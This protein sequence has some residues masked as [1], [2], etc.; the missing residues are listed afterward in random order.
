MKK[1]HNDLTPP[2]KLVPDLSERIDWAIR[3]AMSADPEQRPAIVPGVRRGPDRPQHAPA[4]DHR[5]L[6]RRQ[7]TCG[8]WSTRTRRTSAHGQGN[9]VG[10]RRSLKEGLLGDASTVRASR[11]KAGPF[12][13]LRPLSRSSATW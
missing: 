13:P 8:I 12:E 9:G 10:I 6:P 7:R 11:T 4:A 3:R 5:Q 2:R 1:I